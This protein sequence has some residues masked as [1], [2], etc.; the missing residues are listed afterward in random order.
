MRLNTVLALSLVII[1]SGILIIALRKN[2][3]KPPVQEFAK[4]TEIDQSI[5]NETSE[6][7]QQPDSQSNE[8]CDAFPHSQAKIILG[9][10]NLTISSDT[11]KIEGFTISRC[12]YSINS[13][14]PRQKAS[15]LIRKSMNNTNSNE[16]KAQFTVYQPSSAKNIADYGDA[17]YW[18]S[19]FGELHILNDGSWYVITNGP[20][21]AEQRKLEDAK[22]IANFLKKTSVF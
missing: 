17:A 8:A 22:I 18:N 9:E 6:P 10:N 1:F 11:K 4:V 16:D 20:D 3:A 14:E 2:E 19:D 13:R 7:Q 5:R 12:S 21:N 15:L